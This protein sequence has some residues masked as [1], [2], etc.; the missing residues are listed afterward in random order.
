MTKKLRELRWKID[1]YSAETMPLD[2]L[3]EYLAELAKML[4]DAE[5]LHLVK[6]DTSST[7]PVLRVDEVAIDRVRQRATDVKRGIAPVAVMQSYR[8][9]NVMLRRDKAN[10]ML[11]E[12]SA[13]IIPFPGHK[14]PD[15][16]LT[17]VLQRGSLDGQLEKIGGANAWV[18]VQL[19]SM[20]GDRVAGCYAKKRLAKELG[21]H[22]F[23]PVRLFGRGRWTRTASGQWVLD[24][25]S[26]E[27]FER[28]NSDPLGSVIAA[29]R[30]IKADWR[31]SPVAQILNGE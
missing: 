20:D 14:E 6:V 19:R 31:P 5:H 29:L 27:T 15:D 9:I 17:G 23:E 13:E 7:V 30:S 11:C 2:R 18:P 22:L 24:R 25:F 12:G 10:A 21:G 16:L 4:G 8:R 26:I 28:L 1:A 3:A